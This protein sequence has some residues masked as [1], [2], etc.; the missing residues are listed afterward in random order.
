MTAFIFE[1]SFKS[2]WGRVLQVLEVLNAPNKRT[3]CPSVERIRRKA[4]LK[5]L[6][7]LLR[8]RSSLG[9]HAGLI[10]FGFPLDSFTPT[11]TLT[12]EAQGRRRGG[13]NLWVS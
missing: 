6:Q 11:L 8:I 10:T 5:D 7:D 3:P 1:N 12:H 9:F 4:L 13:S 2:T